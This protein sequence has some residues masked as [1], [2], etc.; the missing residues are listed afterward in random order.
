[1]AEQLEIRV[2]ADLAA[3]TKAFQKLQADI[4]KAMKGGEASFK[5]F[6]SS[7]QKEIPK[8]TNAS[9]RATS[10]LTDLSRIAQDAPY[11]FIGIAN[12]INP[13]LESFGRLKAETG[14]TGAALKGMVAGLAGPAGLGLAIGVISSLLVKFGDSLF[15]ASEKAK[16]LG[17][18]LKDIADAAASVSRSI[19]ELTE[20]LAFFNRAATLKIKIAGGTDVKVLNSEIERNKDAIYDLGQTLEYLNKQKGEL[21]ERSVNTIGGKDTEGAEVYRAM[22]EVDNAIADAMKK[23]ADLTKA[24][25]ILEFQ[26]KLEVK[27]I[28]DDKAKDLKEAGEKYNKIAE[29]NF[30]KYKAIMDKYNQIARQSMQDL[31]IPDMTL[32]PDIKPDV[33]KEVVSNY[34]AGLRQ[35]FED[36]GDREKLN[37]ADLFSGELKSKEFEK[38]VADFN[39]RIQGALS[40]GVNPFIA[41]VLKQ[42]AEALVKAK[43]YQLEQAGVTGSDFDKQILKFQDD[44][45]LTGVI[46]G[47]AL[48]GIANG[49]EA[50]GA[51][52]INGGN[53]FQAFAQGVKQSLVQLAAQLVKTV[54]LAGILS[55]L[56]GGSGFAI[57][58]ITRKG[59]GSIF[60]GLLGFADG[61]LV[62]GPTNALIGE[63]IGTSKSNPEVVA[64][65]DKLKALIGNT[66]GQPIYGE[67]KIKRGDL[68]YVFNQEIKSQR[69]RF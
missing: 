33:Y 38:M 42:Q 34:L 17:T 63:G 31:R 5:K 29:R 4:D 48:T 19:G 1:M 69:I 14:S 18:D 41:S 21:S 52:I 68:V 26:A 16:Y 60:K 7:Y 12:N 55:V 20:T 56:T 45:V 62:T 47:A 15:S 30:E 6:V 57:G 44:L 43:S 65:L 28:N 9:N 39:T 22:K 32:I 46:G 50:I 53:A 13:L 61:G 67:L 37:A 35:A 11:G 27:K 25:V 24:N 23:R 59:F 10:A 64:P 49:F 8:V 3:A 54:A 40:G 66:G 2:G 58:G 36:A 51:S